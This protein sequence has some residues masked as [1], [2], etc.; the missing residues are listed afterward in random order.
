VVEIFETQLFVPA[1]PAPGLRFLIQLTGLARL[2]RMHEYDQIG[3][4]RNTILAAVIRR[5][6]QLDHVEDRNQHESHWQEALR[7]RQ[8]HIRVLERHSGD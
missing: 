8:H 5:K 1:N 6:I 4:Y 3:S 2:E 7:K